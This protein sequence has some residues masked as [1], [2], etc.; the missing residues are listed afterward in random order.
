[1]RWLQFRSFFSSLYSISVDSE[2]FCCLSNGKQ[3]TLKYHT[4]KILVGIYYQNNRK[5]FKQKLNRWWLQGQIIAT[6]VPEPEFMEF[7]TVYDSW[8][9]WLQH[10]F[11]T[12]DRLPSTGSYKFPE[13][14]FSPLTVPTAEASVL[15]HSNSAFLGLSQQKDYQEVNMWAHFIAPSHPLGQYNTAGQSCLTSKRSTLQMKKYENATC[16][17]RKATRVPQ[18]THCAWKW[19]F[20]KSQR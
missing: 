12:L 8:I 13:P 15:T 5:P 18:Y 14:R 16:C 19:Y 11:K 6:I 20:I 7:M 3:Q 2:W 4:H 17:F 10:Q 9:F 1:M